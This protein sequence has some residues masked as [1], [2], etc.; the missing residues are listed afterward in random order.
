MART[1]AQKR[2]YRRNRET[3]L[4]YHHN[5]YQKRGRSWRRKLAAGTGRRSWKRS[6]PRYKSTKPAGGIPRAPDPKHL[7]RGERAMRTSERRE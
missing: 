1:E 4:K 5:Y 6:G 7:L 3:I 2:H